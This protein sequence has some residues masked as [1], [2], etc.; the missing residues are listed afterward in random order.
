MKPWILPALAVGAVVFLLTKP[1]RD[2]QEEIGDHFEDWVDGLI[3]SNHRLQQT[4]G[5]VQTVLER[6]NR[7]LEQGVRD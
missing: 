5:R 3:R 1:G 4:L 7:T 6:C 2:L